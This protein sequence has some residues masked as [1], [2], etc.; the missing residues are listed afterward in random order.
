MH[1]RRMA[2]A[3]LTPRG[4]PSPERSASESFLIT[5]VANVIAVYEAAWQEGEC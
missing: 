2:L 5:P 1:T 3:V 4:L